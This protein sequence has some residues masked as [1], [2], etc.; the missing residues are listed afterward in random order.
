MLPVTPLQSVVSA[1]PTPVCPPRSPHGDIPAFQHS[2]L[3]DDCHWWF[4]LPFKTEDFDLRDLGATSF[5][6]PSAGSLALDLRDLEVTPSNLLP[7]TC[8][9]VLRSLLLHPLLESSRLSPCLTQKL[10][11]KIR[12]RTLVRV[13]CARG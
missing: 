1:S 4:H 2:S 5:R 7:T 10:R 3:V 8:T 6:L 11:R 13:S 9:F 12:K